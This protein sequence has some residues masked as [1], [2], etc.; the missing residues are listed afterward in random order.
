LLAVTAL[1]AVVMHT[2]WYS[3]AG[4]AVDENEQLLRGMNPFILTN[5]V[6]KRVA[7]EID[8]IE[9]Y[10]PSAKAIR[11][12][13]ETLRRHCAEGKQ[14][15]IR[16]DD[17]IP[18]ADWELSDGRAGLE[19]LVGRHL[20]GDPSDWKRVE[21]VYVLYVPEGH[22]WYDEPASG[23]SD[24]I[25]FERADGVA[26]VE[27]VLLFTDELRRDSAGW[28]TVT[29]LER[30]TLVHELGH[31][32]GLVSN[33]AH[34]QE[35]HDRHCSSARCVMHRPGR[36]ARWINGV[37]ALFGH[38]PRRYGSRCRSDIRT[39]KALW[40]ERAVSS[41]RFVERLEALRLFRE[42]I[43]ADEWRDRP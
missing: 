29:K 16:V 13:E 22:G 23:M 37:P 8:W 6:S 5:L 34:A 4:D 32:L 2:P 1:L 9:G 30:S 26:T 43:A 7:L 21:L 15:E 27:T 14:V 41:P 25:T 11:A 38:I 18:R 10:R 35:G 39:A 36:R 12:A 28:I 24:R 42:T 33:P 17:E 19:R 3:T 31:V 20:D 40:A